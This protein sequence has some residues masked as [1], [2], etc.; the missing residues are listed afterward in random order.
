MLDKYVV[1][2]E[3]KKEKRSSSE[4]DSSLEEGIRKFN[5]L[6]TRDKRTL[7]AEISSILNG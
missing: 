4:T 3:L 5:L 7:N 2:R 6:G 1:T